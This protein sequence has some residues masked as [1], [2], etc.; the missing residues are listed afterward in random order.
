M[1]YFRGRAAGNYFR[2]SQCLDFTKV[3][4]ATREI[5]FKTGDLLGAT[6]RVAGSSIRWLSYNTATTGKNALEIKLEQSGI[7]ASGQSSRGLYVNINNES[8]SAIA[9]EL[10]AGE[11]KVRSN[12]SDSP[13]VKGI[14]VSIDAK[15][16]L[17]TLARGIEISIDAGEH[18]H[19][20]FG[21]V[22]GLRIAAN[23]SGAINTAAIGAIIEGPAKWDKGIDFAGTIDKPID[24]SGLTC[25]SGLWTL[26][27]GTVS[28]ATAVK[29]IYLEVTSTKTSSST[30]GIRA[31]GIGN[32][33]SGSAT[34]RGGHFKAN[35]LAGKK[36]SMLE[37]VLAHASVAEGTLTGITNVKG[38]GAFVSSGA[39]VN[40]T[41]LY[42]IT[43]LVQTRGD[44]T[45]GTDHVLLQLKNEAVGGAGKKM[46]SFIQLVGHNLSGVNAADYVIDGGTTK[47]IMTTAFARLPDDGTVCH[48]TDTG[49]G[50]DLQFSD[51][52][53]FIKVVIGS[54]ARYIP[55]L[56]SKP[57]DLT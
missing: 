57:S 21:T 5:K 19:G 44:E 54:A 53:G 13:S 25:G 33:G 10:T 17:I 24:M 14:H 26:F 36:A 1:G 2:P 48:D 50:T 18:V 29:G 8:A 31:E 55:L 6:S 38:L 46:D 34:I 9:G 16:N 7:L 23:W 11:F 52:T 20:N 51:F 12:D 35:L 41:N 56:T 49:P 28:A 30:E 15:A 40:V 3:R 43:V 27:H 37:G 45:I 39:G 4:L 32:A 42:G 22:Q 47:N